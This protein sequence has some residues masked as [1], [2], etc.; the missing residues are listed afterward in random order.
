MDKLSFAGVIIAVAA[1]FIGVYI[2]GGSL[3]FLLQFPAFIIV[4]GG[5]LGAVML[6]SSASQFVHSMKM[7]KWVVTPPVV[8]IDK[9]IDN[10]VLW[11]ERA[12][13]SGYL[14]LENTAITI[15]DRF[16]RKGLNLLVDGIDVDVM[17][18]SL[19]L[20][21]D[22]YQEHHLRSARIIESMGGYSPTIGI[23]GAVLGLIQAMSNID[24]P[25]LLGNGIATAFVATIYGVGLANLLYI[26]IANK[27]RDVVHQQTMFKEMIADGLLAIGHGENPHNIE[28]KLSAY[29][30]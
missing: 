25:E 26:P 11:A 6:Q 27:L 8:N 29:K 16:V 3:G 1:I 15:E 9:G 21:I 4:F 20:D 18:D 24:D 17:R 2:E 7:L 22:V 30:V 14:A 13:E 19:A 23:I 28:R 10:V 5:T 12:R